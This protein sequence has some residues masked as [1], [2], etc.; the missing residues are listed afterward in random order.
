M[1]LGSA[2]LIVPPVPILAG[3]AVRLFLTSGTLLFVELL[4]IRWVP[5]NVIYVGFFSNFVLMASFL[6]IG[7]GILLGRAK[8][9]LPM[10][11]FALLLLGVVGLVM[12]AQLNLHL[13]PADQIFFGLEYNKSA[14]TNFL[15]LPLVM[16]FV[17]SL[18]TVLALP[19]AGLLRSMP[20]LRAYAVDIVGSLTGIAGF[21][22]A[23]VL[24]LE[25]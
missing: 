18:M 10:S 1:A 23:S 9:R 25:P 17:V 12:G 19:L 15:L 24:G 11:P 5:A 6:G 16:A 8:P 20:P 4:L 2:R 22:L 13:D 3:N 14:D 21:G 7:L